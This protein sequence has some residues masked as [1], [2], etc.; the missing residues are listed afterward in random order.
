[1]VAHEIHPT[2]DGVVPYRVGVTH[3]RS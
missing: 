3:G 2:R 1:V